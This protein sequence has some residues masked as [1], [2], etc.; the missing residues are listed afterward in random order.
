MPLPVLIILVLTICWL[1][2]FFNTSIV[3]SLAHTG[4]F[5][6]IPSVVI[7]VLILIHFLSQL[8]HSGFH[9]TD[10]VAISN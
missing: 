1:P 3:P 9:S 2:S 10:R 4:Y 5:S 7:V 8:R 6:D